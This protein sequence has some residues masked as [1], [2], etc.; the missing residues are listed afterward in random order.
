MNL[1]RVEPF[2]PATAS[3]EDLAGLYAVE[4]ALETEALPGEPVAP[5]EH[6]VAGLRH[7]YPFEV[8]KVWVV[9]QGGIA[10]FGS[11]SYRDLP[12]NRHHADVT[13]AVH[14][15]LRGLGFGSALIGRAVEAARRWGC[16]VLDFEARV[17]GQGEPFRRSLG[18][19]RRLIE[20][21][22]RCRTAGIERDRLDGWVRRAGERAAGYSLVGWDGP[23][24]EELLDAF[25]ALKGVMNTAPL[26]RFEWDDERA[27]PEECRGREATAAARRLATWTLCARHDGSGEVVGYTELELPATWPQIAEQGDTG[28]WPKHR[29]RGLGR[30]LKAVNALRLLDE[31]PEVE[32]IDT[33]NAGS[34]DAML[35]INVAMG[36]E[37]LENCGAWQAQTAAVARA[38][39][40]RRHPAAS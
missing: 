12:Q 19:E 34:N 3:D 2:D 30:W 38:L 4:V 20:R 11:C 32:F 14:P 40:R 36:F 10:A 35:G 15:E 25:V 29:D 1:W 23:C 18:A 5:L 16:T 13:V 17:G 22:S 37:P 39:A 24:P 26:E 33:W 21:H 9:R 8:R 31:R 6:T 28:V 7:T 27:T